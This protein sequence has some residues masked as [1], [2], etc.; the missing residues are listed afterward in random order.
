MLS[1]ITEHV[2]FAYR[3]RIEQ[4]M[5]APMPDP[6]E[7]MPQDIEVPFSKMVATVAQRVLADSQ[8]E[9]QVQENEEK[10]EDP[11]LQ[12]TIRNTNI[13]EQE[14]QA[15]IQ[16]DKQKF[17]LQVAKEDND[18]NIDGAKLQQQAAASE[19][20]LFGDIFRIIAEAASSAEDRQL[21]E[22]IEAV[23][24]AIEIFK[25]QREATGPSPERLQ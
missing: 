7:P 20:R 6:Q 2:A 14:I 4:E 18:V 10:L 25:S 13:R 15:K 8:K 23:R 1:H 3:A 22:S 11:I 5:G 21:Q 12:D 19:E 9:A 24:S 16:L 17:Q